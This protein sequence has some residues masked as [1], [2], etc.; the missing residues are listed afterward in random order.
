MSILVGLDSVGVAG[1]AAGRERR[2]ADVAACVVEPQS[3]TG[4]EHSNA[5][6]RRQSSSSLGNMSL[7]P[8]R[9]RHER[10]MLNEASRKTS[11]SSGD[12]GLVTPPPGVRGMVQIMYARH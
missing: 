1:R 8:S 3:G 4:L 6:G 12:S 9:T 2:E 11:R 7:I 10:F 5:T